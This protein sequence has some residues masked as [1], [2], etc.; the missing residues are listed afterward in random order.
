MLGSD[1]SRGYCLEMICADFL[2]GANLDNGQTDLLLRAPLNKETPT[3]L[4]PARYEQLRLRVL[5]RDSWRCQFCGSMT[6]LEVHHRQYRS[7]LGSDDESNLVTL[8][9][10]CHSLTHR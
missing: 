3:R 2:T 10:S 9:H 7:Q 5:S 1:K 4:D 8:C 6:N